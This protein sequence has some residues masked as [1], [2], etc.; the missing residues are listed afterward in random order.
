MTQGPARQSSAGD[1]EAELH[2]QLCLCKCVS[3]GGGTER[4]EGTVQA[5]FILKIVWHLRYLKQQPREK[6]IVKFFKG[7]ILSWTVS[8]SLVESLCYQSR[9]VRHFKVCL[10]NTTLL[11]GIQDF[12]SLS[13][14][15]TDPGRWRKMQQPTEENS[16]ALGGQEP[17]DGHAGASAWH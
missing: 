12:F 14:G 5:L 8:E 2:H 10:K 9:F 7:M 6:T 3:W 13:R 17:G 11:L 4:E 15:W 16:I 1:H